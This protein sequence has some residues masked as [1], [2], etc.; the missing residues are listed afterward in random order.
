MSSKSVTPE[1]DIQWVGPDRAWLVVNKTVSLET[2]LEIARIVSAD[3]GAVR[4]ARSAVA[5]I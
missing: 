4:S 2:A 1:C 3:M 5:P